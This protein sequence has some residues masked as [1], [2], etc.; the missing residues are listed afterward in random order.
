MVAHKD[1][2]S[3]MHKV[4]DHFNKIDNNIR[5]RLTKDKMIKL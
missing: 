3:A 5:S 1:E 4:F 2:K